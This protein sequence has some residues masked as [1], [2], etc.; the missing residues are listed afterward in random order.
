M[1]ESFVPVAACAAPEWNV[2]AEDDASDAD[3]PS[4]AERHTL[5]EDPLVVS[6]REIH[7]SFGV[8]FQ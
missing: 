5:V 3:P 1:V 2:S 6:A 7:I 4:M 8:S